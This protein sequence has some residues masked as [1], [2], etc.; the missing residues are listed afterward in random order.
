MPSFLL[1]AA[2][3][4]KFA[5]IDVEGRVRSHALGAILVFVGVKMTLSHW[6]HLATPTSLAVIVVILG[7]AIAFSAV[8]S[9]RDAEIAE[10]S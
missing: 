1:A 10:V 9:R 3:S 5:A 7:A 8:K 2:E 4:T 6:W